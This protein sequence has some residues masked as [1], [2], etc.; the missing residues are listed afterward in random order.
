MTEDRRG[1][2]TR[3]VI[4]IALLCGGCA[5]LQAQRAR[6]AFFATRGYC[7]DLEIGAVT[8]SSESHDGLAEIGLRYRAVCAGRW[9]RCVDLVTRTQAEEVAAWWHGSAGT[10]VRSCE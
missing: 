6:Q 9:Y 3:F 7:A 4:V 8:A 5:A 2:M 10:P 1:T